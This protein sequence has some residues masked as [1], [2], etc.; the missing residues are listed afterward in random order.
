MIEAERE[1]WFAHDLLDDREWSDYCDEVGHQWLRSKDL[2]EQT[3]SE[4][5]L[6]RGERARSLRGNAG[7]K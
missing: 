4:M 1:F 6:R 2:P 3:I 7:G 5:R